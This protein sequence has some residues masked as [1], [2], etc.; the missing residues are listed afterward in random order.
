RAHRR[1]PASAA[2]PLA[3][4]ASGVAQLARQRE[5]GPVVTDPRPSDLRESLPGFHDGE[6][7][8]AARRHARAGASRR[9]PLAPRAGM[10]GEPILFEYVEQMEVVPAAVAP[11]ALARRADEPKARLLQAALAGQVVRIALALQAVQAQ[12]LERPARARAH[13]L[14]AVA[15]A[16]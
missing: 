15:L 16:P 14:G 13:D 3:V 9:R 6:S 4:V 11:H 5:S 12:L 10:R 7:G 1:V 8:E 2:L